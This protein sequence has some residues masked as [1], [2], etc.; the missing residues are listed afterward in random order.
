[1]LA[2]A[3]TNP[4]KIRVIAE[5]FFLTKKGF[6]PTG[7]D[8]TFWGLIFL[9]VQNV[10]R[11]FITKRNPI[12]NSAPFFKRSSILE[13]LDAGIFR[14]FKTGL[15]EFGIPF[16]LESLESECMSGGRNGLSRFLSHQEPMKQGGP[17]PWGQ[18][19]HRKRLAGQL[20]CHRQSAWL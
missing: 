3:D 6:R 16:L 15:G 4:S 1:M 13:S 14:V 2:N 7:N 8:R 10:K 12:R 11:F 20:G 17:V 9:Q 18:I 5:V 19:H